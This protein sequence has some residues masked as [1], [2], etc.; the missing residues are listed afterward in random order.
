M[1]NIT[2]LE[3]PPGFYLESNPQYC[4]CHDMLKGRTS[5][6]NCFLLNGTGLVAHSSMW[7]NATRERLMTSRECPLDYCYSTKAGVFI[8]L[9][10]NPDAQC[11]FNHSGVLCGGC[12]AD[13][14][15]AIGSSHCV[16]CPNNSN[17]AL[18]LFF[19]A[20]GFLLVLFISLLN[21]TIIQG[22]INGIIF[23]ANIVWVYQSILFPSSIDGTL[24][25]FKVFIAW[26]NLDFGI[27]VCFFRG[28]DAYIKTRLQ[29]VFPFYIWIT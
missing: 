9:E 27:Q 23:Y 29:F 24:I 14:S 4:D 2:F 20:A 17:L 11:A 28:M 12:I 6:S 10:N 15:L 7:V 16:Y 1:I 3:C 8:D 22:M 19:G 13:N 18:L 5:N 21:L 25:F 26:L